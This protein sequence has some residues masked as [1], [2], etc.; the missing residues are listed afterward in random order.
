MA[1]TTSGTFV[2]AERVGGKKEKTETE[3]RARQGGKGGRRK[4]ACNAAG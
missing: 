4:K 1:L 3:T 2:K